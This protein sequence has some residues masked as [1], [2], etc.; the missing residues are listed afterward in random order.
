MFMTKIIFVHSLIQH[1]SVKIAAFTFFRMGMNPVKQISILKVGA[2][3][4]FGLQTWTLYHLESDNLAQLEVAEGALVASSCLFFWAL[5]TSLVRL[6]EVYSTDLP[7]VLNSKGAYKW[8]RHPFYTSYTMMY[9]AGCIASLSPVLIAQTL[10]M[11]TMYFRAARFE[12]R[13]FSKSSLSEAYQE[14]KNKTWMFF[15]GL[16]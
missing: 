6:S 12:E 1:L 15:P 11:F 5:R 14:Y 8:V 2:V 16:L 4:S 7:E 13:K 9:L 10:F 3:L